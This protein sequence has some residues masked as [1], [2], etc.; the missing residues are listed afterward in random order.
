MGDLLSQC[1]L[2]PAMRALKAARGKSAAARAGAQAAF[3]EAVARC[4]PLYLSAQ[5]EV[6]VD[7]PDLVLPLTPLRSGAFADAGLSAGGDAEAEGEDEGEASS[8]TTAAAELAFALSSGLEDMQGLLGAVAAAGEADEAQADV[9][10]Q[11]A[12]VEGAALLG[13]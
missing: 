7:H 11:C 12:E 10:E 8:E 13:C 1:S 5:V 6:L 3:K 9:L 2:H 4:Q